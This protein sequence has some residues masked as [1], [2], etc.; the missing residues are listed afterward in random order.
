MINVKPRIKEWYVKKG[1]SGKE[2]AE[3]LEVSEGQ[4]SKWGKG[5]AYP[6]F[7]KLWKMAKFLGCKMDDLYEE[8][9]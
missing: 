7:E 8:K 1:V 6:R 4:V 5:K 9:E 2:L 3:H